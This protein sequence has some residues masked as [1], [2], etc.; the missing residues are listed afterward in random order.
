MAA[1]VVDESRIFYFGRI[2]SETLR[3]FNNRYWLVLIITGVAIALVIASFIVPPTGVIDPSILAAL[4]ELL[5]FAAL[6]TF[7]ARAEA[8][9]DVT[10]RRGETEI[11]I[12][13]DD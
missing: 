7:I 8:G 9:D 11:T 4:G 3:K 1:N 10:F 12:K 13:T 6:L 2:M 5:G